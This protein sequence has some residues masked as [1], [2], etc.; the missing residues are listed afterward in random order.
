MSEHD[1]TDFLDRPELYS[2]PILCQQRA[3]DLLEEAGNRNITLVDTTNPLVALLGASANQAAG[4]AIQADA[5][6]RRLYPRL[7][8]TQEDLYAHMSDE[9][10]VG[11]FA[12]PDQGTIQVAMSVAQILQ[13]AVMDTVTGLRTL[14]IPADTRWTGGEYD[15]YQHH[16]ITIQIVDGDEL[17]VKLDT[18]TNSTVLSKPASNL[19]TTE[20]QRIEGEDKIR[21]YIPVEQLRMESVSQ[22][23]SSSSGL[24]KHI[25]HPD[26]FYYLRAW[27]TNNGTE[28]TEIYVT[29]DDQIYDPYRPTVIVTV[30]E[31]MI[32]VKMPEVYLTNG[33]VGSQIRL[34]VYTTKGETGFDLSTL[35]PNDWSAVFADPNNRYRALAG[36]LT[37]V[38][39]L[40]IASVSLLQGG[41]KALSFDLLREKTVYGLKGKQTSVTDAE[42]VTQLR[43]AGYNVS[44]IKNT[45]AGRTYLASRTLPSDSSLN[46]SAGIGVN[47]TPILVDS[48]RLDLPNS[49]V[50]NDKRTA[51]KPSALFESTAA[52]V[53]IISD[54]KADDI[55]MLDRIGLVERVNQNELFYTPFHYILDATQSVFDARAYILDRPSH[56]SHSYERNNTQIGYAVTTS[57]VS[58]VL[59]DTDYV[60]TVV[61]DVPNGLYGLDLQ[62][63]YVNGTERLSVLADRSSVANGQAVFTFRMSTT[64]DIDREN[65]LTINNFMD[66]AG[67]I[68]DAVT[69]L[70]MQLEF[71]YVAETLNQNTTAFDNKISFGTLP[72]VRTGVSYE[73]AKLNLG[74]H[75]DGLFARTRSLPHPPV[76]ERYPAD[77]VDTYDVTEYDTRSD[78]SIIFELVGGKPKARILH[79]KGDPKLIDG[80][81]VVRHNKGDIVYNTDSGLPNILQERK[82]TRE[83]RFV[84]LDAKFLFGDTPD[85]IRYRETIPTSIRRYLTGDI[86]DLRSR[87]IERTD[88]YFEPTSTTQSAT[89]KVDAGREIRV[90]TALGFNV[91][92]YMSKAGVLDNAL[93]VQVANSVREIIRGIVQ[94]TQVSLNDIRG[95]MV[96]LR[97]NDILDISIEDTL[98]GSGFITITDDGA[99]FAVRS[100]VLPLTNSKLDIEDDINFTYLEY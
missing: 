11:R 69:T 20:R 28:W 95:A 56:I 60:A 19:I 84:L 66:G 23:I 30:L 64:L 54:A 48:D 2:T 90:N 32:R 26:N 21:L 58:L 59:D 39:D 65:K 68:K 37:R 34:D 92:V 98:P 77:V 85:V 96:G 6:M 93:R 36:P 89:A 76:Y 5:L 52:G 7:A 17:L 67:T 13:N 86:E 9:D 46:A 72:G 62:V 18:A 91:T 22:P 43:V 45:V 82:Y 16:P 97:T 27:T 53:N 71:L 61:A 29:H 31:G 81:P 73:V 83:V 55:R 35:V 44:L 10:Y 99:E 38:T 12:K 8:Q 25:T 87:L 74:Q 42:L 70:D 88:L 50:V 75:M 24:N 78:G 79:A 100:R 1:Y 51:I 40:T 57:S 63:V 80:E 4:S 41:R 33:S 49:M 3:I 47:C 14:V 94:G 15:F